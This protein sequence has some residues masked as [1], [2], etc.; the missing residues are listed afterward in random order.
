MISKVS[1]MKPLRHLP[2]L[3]KDTVAIAAATNLLFSVLLIYQGTQ[4]IFQVSMNEATGLICNPFWLQM[5]SQ[6]TRL[7]EE[8]R[9]R[10]TAGGQHCGRQLA[11]PCQAL[12]GSSWAGLDFKCDNGFTDTA[13][14][15]EPLWFSL[16]Y[17]AGMVSL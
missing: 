15:F 7:C 3:T 10:E 6:I 1:L 13:V 11:G 5:L 9:I 12:G 16:C 8:W 4:N 17:H 14:S 2:I